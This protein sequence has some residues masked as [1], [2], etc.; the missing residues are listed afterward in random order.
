MFKKTIVFT[1]FNGDDQSQDFYFHMSKAELLAMAAD[2]SAMVNR[3]QRIIEAKD[4]RAI[5]Q[6]FRELIEMS[7][8]I[9]SEDGSRFIKDSS[10]K[11]Q[12][13]D[14]PAFDELLMDLATNAEASAE[15]V[16]QL[17]PEKMQEQMRE[18]LAKQADVDPFK[19]PVDGDPR[20][21]WLK[22]G[23]TPTEQELQTMSREEMAMAFR[24]RT[25][26]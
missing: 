19:N 24:H 10:A 11:S 6:E 25:A 17:I 22:E 18:Q 14:S 1:D 4:G 12:L 13:M 15:F 5:L 3:I 20:P 23:R 8:G 7:V 21:T 26:Q 9:R 2:N 16:R